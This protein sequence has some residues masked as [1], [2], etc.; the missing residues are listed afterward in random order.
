M[1]SKRI[2]TLCSLLFPVQTFADVG[3]DHGYCTEYMLKNAL[4]AHATVTDVSA[5]CLKKAELLLADFMTSGVCSS[6]C[7]DGL[8][9]VSEN[10]DLVLIAGMGGIEIVNI[11]RQ[12]FI[13]KH[14]V[15]QP[16]RDSDK[17]R[18]Y[19]LDSAAYIQRDFT[20]FDGKYYDVITG[21]S[22][23]ER[24]L[25]EKRQQ[26][27]PCELQF[28]RENIR[29]RREDFLGFLQ[30]EIN[31]KQNI[32]ARPLNDTTRREM[33]EKLRYLQGVFSGEIE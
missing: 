12:G 17:V 13:P 22:Q 8:Q 31:K 16:M 29:E 3:C 15:L 5:D 11:L 7:T 23:S 26:Y 6:L 28:G 27:T 18:K 10:T 24:G 14:F 2:Q 1:Y 21:C 30:E 20:F 9:G 4:C 25:N 33:Q 32:L 19:L